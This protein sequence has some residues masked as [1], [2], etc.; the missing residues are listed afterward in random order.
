MKNVCDLLY[1]LNGYGGLYSINKAGM[2]WSHRKNKYLTPSV[3][4]CGYL[5][6]RLTKE[7][8]RSKAPFVARL[9][10]LQFIPNPKNLP[11]VNHIDG[12]KKNNSAINLQW[13]S[14]AGSMQHAFDT[15]LHSHVGT[16]NTRCILREQ[17]VIAIRKSALSVKE[18]A[19]QYGVS[20]QTVYH[21][22]KKISWGHI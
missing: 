17:D 1:P 11:E 4:W 19:I 5:T 10:A 12:N 13:V 21:A 2:I 16:K 3:N 9:V 6:V 15:G 7:Y 14:R 22:K 18:L 20:P 8:K